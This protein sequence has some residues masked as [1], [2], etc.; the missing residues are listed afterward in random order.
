M[1][2]HWENGVLFIT[3]L[4]LNVKHSFVLDNNT[5]EPF[6]K[7]LLETV[8]RSSS[9]SWVHYPKTVDVPVIKS[10]FKL[11]IENELL[12]TV[13]KPNILIV[14]IAK[15]E[16]SNSVT[17]I[18]NLV[19]YF[20]QNRQI[21]QVFIW[22]SRKN[23]RDEKLIPFLQYLANIEVVLKNE[24]E[25]HI[26]TKRNT[27]TVTRKVCVNAKRK[28]YSCFFVEY[29]N[30]M[31]MVF[32]VR[33]NINTQSKR[34]MKFQFEKSRKHQLKSQTQHQLSIQNHYLHSRFQPM[35]MS[36]QQRKH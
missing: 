32:H 25:M 1:F 26:L 2:I 24:S 29:I 9:S 8:A 22:C 12:S 34:I 31:S 20:K 14:P 28:N 3:N 15:L 21:K 30:L 36:K 19:H 10:S 35:E 33:R 23:I 4:T 18:V 7:E 5:Y 13:E 6:A 16:L 27:G 11:D 17:E